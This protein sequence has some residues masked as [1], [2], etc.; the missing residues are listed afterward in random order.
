MTQKT[1]SSTL[2]GF[3]LLI[4][5]S[6]AA[7]AGSDANLLNALPASK[8]SL[9]A[10]IQQAQ[11]KPPETAISAKFEIDDKG[12]L[13]LSVYTV[14]RKA[15]INIVAIHHHMAGETPRYLFLHY[16]GRGRA[17]ALARGVKAALDTQKQ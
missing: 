7:G 10:G 17:D 14:S 4:G 8:Q 1:L 5:A 6:M 9:A 12:R 16:W 3:A 11:A 13:A 15:D 2:A